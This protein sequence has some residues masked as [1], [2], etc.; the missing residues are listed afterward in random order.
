MQK[1][2]YEKL[3]HDYDTLK[4]A[5]M[6]QLTDGD[7]DTAKKRINKLIRDVNKCITVLSGK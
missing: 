1:A 7:L 3:L 5:K 6:L 4:M 2:L